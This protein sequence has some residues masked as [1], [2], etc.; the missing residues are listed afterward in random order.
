MIRTKEDLVNYLHSLGENKNQRHQETCSS[1]QSEQDLNQT[2][3]AELWIFTSRLCSE[4]HYEPCCPFHSI[5]GA[6]DCSETSAFFS[7]PLHM[8]WLNLSVQVWC[9]LHLFYLFL[10]FPGHK[11]KKAEETEPILSNPTEECWQ[12]NPKWTTD[13]NWSAKLMEHWESF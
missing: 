6:T 10:H 2:E 12:D 5:T 7:P 3:K 11:L 8:L 9:G 1:S 13:N 4:Y